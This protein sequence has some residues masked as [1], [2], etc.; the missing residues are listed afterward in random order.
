MALINCPR[1]GGSGETEHTHIV[2]GICFLCKGS[3]VITE[4]TFELSEAKKQA[5]ID[6]ILENEK[7]NEISEKNRW[8]SLHGEAKINFDKLVSES[9][10]DLNIIKS[11][12][13]CI[14]VLDYKK[15]EFTKENFE[16]ILNDFSGS[17]YCGNKIY[18]LALA[19]LFRENNVFNSKFEYQNDSYDYNE[20]R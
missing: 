13:F 19:K 11:F 10:F 4:R 9:D 1:C 7:A 14:K 17:F 18:R 3:G 15:Q 2:Y 5:K 8:I 6:R 16:E 12:L 20:Y